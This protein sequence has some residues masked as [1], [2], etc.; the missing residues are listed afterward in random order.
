MAMPRLLAP[1]DVRQRLA[2]RYANHQG[3]WLIGEGTWPI[4][5]ALGKP[6]ES[7]AQQHP[8]AVMAWV[9]AWQNWQGPGALTWQDRQWRALGVQRLPEKMSLPDADAVAAW[10]GEETRWRQARERFHRL[11]D[12]WPSLEKVLSRYFSVLAD[13]PEAEFERLVNLLDWL[14][15]HPAS[16]LYPRQ[17][18][19]SGVDSKWIEGHTGVL[20]PLLE[21]LRGTTALS[22]NFYTD[23]GL[24]MPPPRLR[25][26]ILDPALRRCLG[27]L[28]DVKAPVTDIAA[29]D[30]HVQCVFIVENL[31][32]GLSFGELPGAVVFM[33]AGYHV[34]ALG[35]LPWLKHLPC[36]YWGDLD[37]HG[38]AILHRARGY[39]PQLQSILMDQTTLE[40]Y[41]S[42]WTEEPQPHA[43]HDLPNLTAD[44]RFVYR[45]LKEERWGLRVRLEQ[46]RV[47]WT[48][49]WAEIREVHQRMTRRKNA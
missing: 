36:I 18:P 20:R 13:Y 11:V 44:E 49:A 34:E 26:R 9:A 42:L 14:V 12:R 27:G 43:A 5:M 17:L 3:N 2:K 47:D 29:M 10:L 23:C 25:F 37:T 4:E 15:A 46:E 39:L 48:T 40:T 28:G 8:T 33:G 32:T 22:T 35:E 7:D 19:V 24:R 1:D 6:R 38:F 30:W 21:V 31:Q 41:R 45:G 16:N